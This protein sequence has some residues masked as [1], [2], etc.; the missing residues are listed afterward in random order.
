MMAPVSPGH[1]DAVPAGRTANRV[2]RPG[3]RDP[4]LWV[5]VVLVAASVLAGARL[6]AGADDTVVVWA[7]QR[8][9][10]A[11]SEV[12]VEDLTATRVRFADEGDLGRYLAATAD[13]PAERRL[14]HDV[15]AGDLLPLS[16]LGAPADTGVLS[17]PISLP[18][19]AV[20][21]DVGPGARVDVWVTGEGAGGKP[22]ARPVL[23]DVL[24]LA[25]PESA[26]GFGL[27]TDRQLVLG[28]DE[29][30]QD[31]LGRVL[32]GAGTGGLT[33]VGRG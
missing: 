22:V 3:W 32:A 27:T 19:L 9:L 17:V 11:G 20:P 15:A 8:D 31:V 7:A 4:R 23:S 14:R 13:L 16:A 28:V 6:L 21:P 26:E 24:V 30:Q 10:S 5:G 12:A 2:G 33:V 25:A 1:T 29:S 18:A